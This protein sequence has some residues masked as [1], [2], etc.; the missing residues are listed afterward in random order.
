MTTA[1]RASILWTTVPPRSRGKLLRHGL[2]AGG[3]LLAGAATP[4]CGRELVASQAISPAPSP[5]C[6][7]A[8]LSAAPDVVE[9]TSTFSSRDGTWFWIRLRDSTAERGQRLASIQRHSPE[10]TG[11]TMH[12][13]WNGRLTR[14][15]LE[16]RRAVTTLAHRVL[17]Q[18]RACVPTA[19][20]IPAQCH[21][22]N[23]KWEP[24][25]SAT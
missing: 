4:T 7:A 20:E 19:P 3:F 1:R 14:P 22:G 12:F 25:A 5:E 18:L 11:L 17:A 21:W 9:I 6:L 16:E 10:A 13:S 23:G 15:P 8:T 2:L 24:C